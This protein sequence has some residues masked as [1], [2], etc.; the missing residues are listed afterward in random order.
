VKRIIVAAVLSL[1]IASF[2]HAEG[3]NASFQTLK[4]RW[5]RPDGGYI[6]EIKAV[7]ADGA[8]DAAYFNPRPINVERASAKEEAGAIKVFI[9]LRGAGYPG[10]TYDLIYDAERDQLAGTYY[11]A[12]MRETFDIYFKRVK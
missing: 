12:V 7:S 6:I 5:L 1:L 11:Q 10:S 8:L 2:V 9:V 3:T 4:G